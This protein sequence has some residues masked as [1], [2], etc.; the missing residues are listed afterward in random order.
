[1]RNFSK[2]NSFGGAE[3]YR[4]VLLLLLLMFFASPCFAAD[5]KPSYGILYNTK[6][7]SGIWFECSEAGYDTLQCEFKQMSVF[8]KAQESELAK[9]IEEARQQFRAA[10][11]E[12]MNAKEC[13]EIEDMLAGLRGA[14]SNI[15][16]DV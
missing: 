4:A 16:P 15:K 5:E 11:K 8:K 1:M 10:P 13:A 3:M 12:P 9:K 14:K 2:F 6:E 7:S